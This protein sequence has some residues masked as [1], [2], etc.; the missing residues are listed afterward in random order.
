MS[1]GTLL[2]RIAVLTGMKTIRSHVKNKAAD[3][4]CH[5]SSVLEFI[6]NNSLRS[7]IMKMKVC[8]GFVMV[9][10]QYVTFVH[11]S[12]YGNDDFWMIAGDVFLTTG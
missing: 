10:I 4:G 7:C 1:C 5:L 11:Q 2:D 9:V 6:G 12:R 3:L 8:S